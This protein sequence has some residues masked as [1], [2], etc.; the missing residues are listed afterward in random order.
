MTTLNIAPVFLGRENISV[1]SGK[2]KFMSQTKDQHWKY[3]MEKA[4]HA[5]LNTSNMRVLVMP[6]F[7]D[8]EPFYDGVQRALDT[9]C[10]GGPLGCIDTHDVYFYS[11]DKA[12]FAAEARMCMPAHG[13]VPY[14]DA[15]RARWPNQGS[16]EEGE[17][18]SV[19]TWYQ[20]TKRL[21]N[22]WEQPGGS[23]ILT[24]VTRWGAG[25]FVYPGS[26]TWNGQAFNPW[27]P[28]NTLS[29][30]EI[31]HLLYI[32]MYLCMLDEAPRME[33]IKNMVKEVRSKPKMVV[34]LQH[35]TDNDIDMVTA[36]PTLQF[37]CATLLA[38]KIRE[39]IVA[40]MCA[41]EGVP[42]P[43]KRARSAYTAAATAAGEAARDPA[44]RRII[45]ASV[46]AKMESV[47]ACVSRSQERMMH[48]AG[49]SL[50]MVPEICVEPMVWSTRR[51]AP[52]S[53]MSPFSPFVMPPVGKV[54]YIDAMRKLFPRTACLLPGAPTS[55]ETWYQATKRMGLA[56]ERPDGS[57]ILE[58][59]PR[60]GNDVKKRRSCAW[61]GTFF[62]P[63]NP[64]EPM[65]KVALLD[66]LYAPMY[67]HLLDHPD[68][69]EKLASI[70]KWRDD[71]EFGVVVLLDYGANSIEDVRKDPLK[72]LAHVSF[73]VDRLRASP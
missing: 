48:D 12:D 37:S 49:R 31:L 64:A 27:Q 55:V 33:R 41:D 2:I 22:D 50:C 40:A 38:E 58:L 62:N 34:G 71:H 18:T 4:R 60:Q 47:K 15:M 10:V 21:G 7:D 54:V 26:T 13:R 69:Q 28:D 3:I 19:E 65:Q 70:S 57:D 56:N 51:S 16:L 39:Q 29:K 24:R 63:F 42:P 61:D 30:L 35:E 1:E 46:N 68:R 11:K 43:K 14:I 67:K 6:V 5:T 59:V 25:V 32:P 20:A 53:C 23:G 66:A 9:M 45:V 44:N 52:H 17:P 72:V 73:I 36:D 8:L